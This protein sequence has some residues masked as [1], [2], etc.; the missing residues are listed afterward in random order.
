MSTPQDPSKS[1]NP[2][3]TLAISLPNSWH[4]TPH[5]PAIIEVEAIPKHPPS[6]ALRLQGPKARLHHSLGWSPRSRSPTTPRAESPTYTRWGHRWGRRRAHLLVGVPS[7]PARNRQP[8][9]HKSD[10]IPR[11]LNTL[12]QKVPRGGAPPPHAPERQNPHRAHS[13]HRPHG[14]QDRT[15]RPG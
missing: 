3:S 15:A 8:D 5:Q 10:P 1:P 4:S 9:C 13:L 11:P 14:R 6:R 2:L 7:P 12:G